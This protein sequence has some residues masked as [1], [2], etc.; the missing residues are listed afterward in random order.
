[1]K[2]RMSIR[3]VTKTNNV[4][5]VTM[6]RIL[7]SLILSLVLVLGVTGAVLADDP[8]EVNVTWDGSGVVITGVDSGDSTT[9]LNTGGVGI[10]GSFT[11]VD[12]N[13]NP[14]G[15]GVDTFTASL[16]AN[17]EDGGF[18][19]LLTERLNSKSSSYGPAGQESYT[20]VFIDDG[21]ASLATRTWTNYAS[22]KD[23]TYGYQLPGGHNIVV[24]SSAYLISR[25]I[26]D[27]QGNSGE[28]SATGSGTAILDD[29][30]NE[31][32]GNGGVRFGWGCG[33]YTDANYNATGSGT[34]SVT[35]TGNTLV[36]FIGLG[37]SSGGGTL[38]IV[39]NFIDGFSINNY[40]VTAR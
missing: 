25:Y 40:A 23:P 38:G 8:T 28:I 2:R 31:V 30:S 24:S 27:G 22:M 19:Q 14:Y 26:L 12:S 17:V 34:F 4:K 11:V 15:Y 7:L 33:C 5:G 21:V 9:S 10:S 6:K 35:G 13:D 29:M 36:D 16:N 3:V 37:M 20:F 1:M 39:A 18:I 32:S